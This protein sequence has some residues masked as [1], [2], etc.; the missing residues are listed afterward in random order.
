MNIL[1]I[2]CKTDVFKL[3]AVDASTL[4]LF[5]CLNLTAL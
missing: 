2:C 1:Y 3:F 5:R 4:F